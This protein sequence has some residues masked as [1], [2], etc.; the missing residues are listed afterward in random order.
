MAEELKPTSESIVPEILAPA[1][2][3]PQFFAALNSGADAVYLGL[4]QFNAR[5]RAAN[6]SLA[7]LRAIAPIARQHDVKILVTLN[8]LLKQSELKEM[9]SLLTELQTSDIHAV[10]VQDLALVHLIR[11]YF[12]DLR[13]H[14]STQMA[15]HNV[16]GVRQAAE[17]GIRR[18]VLARELTAQELRLIRAAVPRHAIELEAFCHGSLCYSYSGLCFFSGIGDGRSGNRGECAYTCREPYKIVSEPGHGFLFS[19][20]DLDTSNSIPKFVEAGI[21]TL[22]IEGRKKDAQYV[23]SVVRLYRRKLDDYFGRSTLRDSAPKT[24]I[25][26]PDETQIRSDL[27]YSFQRRPTSFFFNGRYHENVIDLDNP[28]HLGVSAGILQLSRPGWIRF[29]TSVDLALHDGLRICEPSRTFHSEPQHGSEKTSDGRAGE[30]RYQNREIQF[31]IH[32]MRVDGKSKFEVKAGALVEIKLPDMQNQVVN[33]YEVRKQRSAQLKAATEK[34]SQ[35]TDR[36]APRQYIKLRIESNI[37]G[38]ARSIKVAALL[39]EQLVLSRSFELETATIADPQLSRN[40][41]MQLF[42]IM[43]DAGVAVLDF[44]WLGDFSFGGKPSELKSIK[45]DFARDLALALES[46]KISTANQIFSNSVG[47]ERPRPTSEELPFKANWTV[48]IDRFEYIDFLRRNSNT[49]FVP[50]EVCFE[51]KRA[52]FDQHEFSEILRA[53]F[54]YRQDHGS[55]VRLAIPS[56]VRGWDL[57]LLKRWCDLF[58]QSGGY[59]FEIGNIGGLDLLNQLAPKRDH[60]KVSADFSCYSLNSIA[61]DFWAKMNIE[62]VSLSIEDD[63]KNLDALM[64]HWPEIGISPQLIVYKDSPLFIAEACSLTALHNGCPSAKVCGYR[65]LEIEN[66]KGDRFHVAHESCRSIVYGEKALSLTNLHQ[67]LSRLH[68]IQE[69]RL[70]FLTRPYDYE[71]MTSIIG[72][73]VDG[74]SLAQSHCGN[75]AGSLL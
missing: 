5:A 50:D 60:I 70:D 61:V 17:L 24:A 66:T 71:T 9:I 45:R 8:I 37:E 75:F 51:P 42:G 34:L 33:G 58:L 69:L 2:G 16:Q 43:G 63:A 30:R 64:K 46:H 13:I 74:R 15:I 7:E 44:E 48:K 41:L 68:R 32:E 18:A 56:I 67:S 52:F 28:T 38:H 36:L 4:R 54:Q 22:K 11:R 39:G 6:F 25:N 47:N 29:K 62:R 53:L 31:G 49:G 12:P 57:S 35:P 27:S 3:M 19:M 59:A 26:L 72:A 55:T 23:S 73:A 10:I 65:T 1:G 21:D 14:A 20:G 40:Q